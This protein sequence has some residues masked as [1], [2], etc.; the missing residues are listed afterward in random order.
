[1]KTIEELKRLIQAGEEAKRELETRDRVKF[2]NPEIVVVGP[3]E[4][5]NWFR[6]AVVM[7]SDLHMRVTL[8]RIDDDKLLENLTAVIK[9]LKGE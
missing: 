7:L 4:R 9:E 3:A 2:R 1:M 5:L 8:A 6:K